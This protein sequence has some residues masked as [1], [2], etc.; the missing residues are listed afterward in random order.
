MRK[1]LSILTV[2][3][4]SRSAVFQNLI[5]ALNAQSDKTVEM[6]AN[7]DNGEKSIGAKRNELLKAAKGDYVVFVDD[8]DM[9]SPYYVSSILGAIKSG[10]DCCG[11][12]GIITTKTFGPRKFIHS[13]KYTDWY[14]ENE[15]YYRCPNHL[16]P[17]KRE[18]ALEV[19]FPDLSFQEDKD[20]S[21]R[22][23][24]KLQTEV[25]INQPLYYYY[26]STTI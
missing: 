10:P 7:L 5:R 4:E 21:L 12:E 24:G 20:F 13:L 9:V 25:Y 15:V 1:H 6:L 14:E 2:T 17:I 3:L 19:G 8:D 23:K 16:N 18:I 22:L 26:P 11:L